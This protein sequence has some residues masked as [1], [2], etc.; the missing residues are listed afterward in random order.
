MPTWVV[1]GG[2]PTQISVFRIDFANDNGIW[3]PLTA[4]YVIRDQQVTQVMFML[5]VDSPSS[6]VNRIDYSMTVTH[7]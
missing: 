3:G 1:A 2:E 6:T 7:Q 5:E 4:H